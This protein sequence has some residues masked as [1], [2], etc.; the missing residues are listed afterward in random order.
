MG[1]KLTIWSLLQHLRSTCINPVAVTHMYFTYGISDDA[2]AMKF[3]TLPK[4]IPSSRAYIKIKLHVLKYQLCRK[5]MLDCYL[6]KAECL[7]TPLKH[8]ADIQW[9][10]WIKCAAQMDALGE[11]H[12]V[13]LCAK[14]NLNFS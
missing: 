5:A 7:P 10:D 9:S 12:P 14:D 6:P 3:I 2:H 8:S 11:T 4:R 1:G 13:I